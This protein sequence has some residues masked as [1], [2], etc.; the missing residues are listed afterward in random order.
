MQWVHPHSTLRSSTLHLNIS[1]DISV[2]LFLTVA[3]INACFTL[4]LSQKAEKWLNTY[5]NPS[6]LGHLCRAQSPMCQSTLIQN[7]WPKLL[8]H[9]SYNNIYCSQNSISA[10]VPDL[11]CPTVCNPTDCS[12]P[13]SSVHGISQARI[14]EWVA[15]S[16][17]RGSSPP[18]DWTSISYVSHPGRQILYH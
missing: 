18:R 9:R 8:Y 10:P 2:S 6:F 3:K 15:I 5:F 17:S 11:L 16:Y 13:D 7:C 12:L 4:D 14:L 1:P